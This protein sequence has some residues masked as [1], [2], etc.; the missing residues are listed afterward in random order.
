MRRVA[1][2]L[3]VIVA[4]V[5][6]IVIVRAIRFVPHRVIV[7]AATAVDALPG[8]T[9]RLA[10]AVRIPT[11]SPGDSTQR[12]SA[13]FLAIHALLEKSFPR[14]HATMGREVVGR[15]A[16]LYTWRG[17][18]ST[19][20]PVVL[21]GHVDVVPVE[22]GT[23]TRW[24]HPPFS[25][26]I[27]DGYVWGRGTLDDK[28]TVLG[29]LEA[30][31]ALLAQGFQPR[32]TV[33][34][35]FGADEEVGGSRG[36]V[37]IAALLRSRGVRPFVVIDE[38]G[39]VVS[40]VMP[41]VRAPLAVVGIAEKGFVSVELVTSAE[42]GHSAMPPRTTAAGIVARAVTRLEDNPFQAR[43]GG[44][45]AE[46]LD[47]VGR[48]MSFGSRVVFANRWLFDPLIRRQLGRAP[49]T[50]ATLRTTTAVTMLEGSPKDNVLPSRARAVVNLR[51]LPGDSV[52]GVVE[53]VRRVVDDSRV[54]V[55]PVGP[56]TEPSPL[57]PTNDAAWAVLERSIRQVYPDAVIVPY[58]VVGATDSRH[59]RDLTPNVYRFSPGRLRA[60]DLLRPHGINERIAVDS[61]LEGVRFLTRLLRNV[62]G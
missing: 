2:T 59:F 8:A 41:G 35:A 48:E 36:A 42:G 33:Y 50:D 26:A 31:E 47:A 17:S 5:V 22:S 45:V 21:M 57:S 20:A 14:V 24:T 23:E 13:A 18:D 6:G 11:I 28:S 60:D 49:S 40:G 61:Y 30:S 4:L 62:A 53:R 56:L 9:D 44:A 58:L 27:V 12:D 37:P 38:G 55:R 39:T 16:L 52:S 32:R 1:A 25:G 43:I 34:L 7:P 19:L 10:A 29:V 54:E 46:Q 15:D 51:I 3:G